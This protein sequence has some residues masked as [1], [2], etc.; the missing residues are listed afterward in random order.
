MKIIRILELS[1]PNIWT[2]RYALEAWVDLGPYEERPSNLIPGFYERLTAWLP[3]LVE[4][5][6][7]EGERGGF[8]SRLRDGTWFG[9][10]LEH[11]S[12]ELQTQVYE[13]VG[14]GRARETTERGIY[15]VVI[16]CLAPALGRACL[17]TGVRLLLAAANEKPFALAAE[18]ERLRGVARECGLTVPGRL[19]AAAARVRGIPVRRLLG[20]DLLLLGYG[21]EQR[22]F[23]GSDSD[24]TTAVGSAIAGDAELT[25]KLL[26]QVGLPVLSEVERVPGNRSEV[27][28]V[29]DRVLGAFVDFNQDVPR[30]FTDR[31][32]AEVARLCVLAA[33]TLGLGSA[34]IEL[35]VQDL[36][37]SLAEQSAAVV[38]AV[39]G[40]DLELCARMSAACGQQVA[41]AVLLDLIPLN[42][43]PRFQLVSISGTN[44]KS[45]VAA[46]LNAVLSASGKRVGRA[47]QLA[48]LDTLAPERVLA[49]PLLDAAIVEVAEVGVLEHGGPFDYCDVAVVTNLGSGDH[50]GRRYLQ[51]LEFAKKAIRTP[52][53]VVRPTG[54]AVLNAEDLAVRSLAQYCKGQVVYFSTTKPSAELWSELGAAA[55][56]VYADYQRVVAATGGGEEQLLVL[57]PDAVM[58][59][60]ELANRLAATAAGYV[61]GIEPEALAA[62]WTLS[63]S[64]A[65]TLRSGASTVRVSNCRNVSALE[66][67]LAAIDASSAHLVITVAPDWTERDV[68]A[69][70]E[71]A[72]TVAALLV[73]A[74]SADATLAPLAEQLTRAAVAAGQRTV[75]RFDELRAALQSVMDRNGQGTA[76]VQ[77]A[78]REES[79]QLVAWLAQDHRYESQRSEGRIAGASPVGA[80]R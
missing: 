74:D 46:Y 4:H 39:A 57:L 65:S 1:G 36:Q 64:D 20:S 35:F 25:R 47:E 37:L 41:E 12:L 24:Q 38:R 9:H 3:S 79:R 14:Y 13:P 77:T 48:V 60:Y 17:E 23:R 34:T 44:G 26:R 11:V 40:V 66:A 45:E 78:D 50:L 62:G 5:R 28:V 27:V 80:G 69:F 6:C 52:V 32:H 55:Q 31:L 29:G 75:L 30:R 19:I 22:R 33:R 10:I 18:L 16:A 72:A 63:A 61:L 51:D 70:G 58:A 15:R 67:N 68:V 53:D 56:V 7:S 54:Y 73:V 49:N 21:A 71:R 59:G 43:P 2:N 8:L 76:L 42:G